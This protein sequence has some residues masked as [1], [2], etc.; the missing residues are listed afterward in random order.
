MILV[1]GG[2]IGALLKSYCPKM[3][4]TGESLGMIL[5]VLSIFNVIT[6]C[7][8]NLSHKCIGKDLSV[9]QSPAIKW[10]L[11]DII[12]LSAEFGLCLYGGTN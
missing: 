3:C 9:E 6:A 12:A 10:S 5:D 4:V 7:R 11:N 1:P 8:S 2:A